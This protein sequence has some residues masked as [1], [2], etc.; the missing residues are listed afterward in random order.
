MGRLLTDSTISAA[1]RR[2]TAGRAPTVTLADAAPRG[3]G[4]LLLRVQPGRAEWFAQRFVD[5]RRRLQKLGS[6]PALSLAQ[7]REQFAA[8]R[9]A[10]GRATL[11][12]LLDAYVAHLNGRASQRQ[13]RYVLAEAGSIIGRS[14][15]A[16][17]VTPRDIVSVIKPRF[18]A[19]SRAAAA[20]RRMYL[21]A[22]FR[23]AIRSAH[24]YR[25]ATPRHWG[26]AANPVDAVPVDK[27]ATRAGERWLDIDEW[28]QVWRWATA[29]RP[30]GSR[31]VVALLLLTGQRVPEITSLRAEQWD[32]AERILHWPTTKNGW[33]HTIPVCELAALLLDALQPGPGGYLFPG[34]S[35]PITHD[36]VRARLQA[37]RLPDFDA[38]DL[39]RTWKTL[40]GEA[41]LSK[42]VR[43]ALQ[44]HGRADVA[45][46]HY[47]RWDGMPEKREAV[48]RWGQW[49]AEQLG[50]PNPDQHAQQVVQAQHDA[51]AQHV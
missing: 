28:R 46:R 30:G 40:A 48:S 21:S 15:L 23:W 25:T 5:G 42:V 35:G 2:V 19:G 1:V 45:S 36:A 10:D 9:P 32:S 11:G 41:G 14:R 33:P 39:R 26:L 27:G 3:A 17:D 20:K 13:A 12:E 29:G 22:A 43:D 50:Q 18:A 44:H 4:R 6:Y 49:L 37:G 34:R 8:H 7:A 47:D 38:R 24:D 16:R 31:T 51:Q